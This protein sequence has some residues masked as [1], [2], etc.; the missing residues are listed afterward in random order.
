LKITLS[1]KY[2]AK[3]NSIKNANDK[4]SSNEQQTL[5]SNVKIKS[6]P[7]NFIPDVMLN[8]LIVPALGD[9]TT[10]SIFIAVIEKFNVK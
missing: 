8:V 4:R 6:S 2:K 7:S 10:I 1:L 5:Y 3:E 9:C